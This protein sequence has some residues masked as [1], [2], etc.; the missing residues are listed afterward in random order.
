MTHALSWTHLSKRLWALIPTLSLILTACGG[1]PKP[2]PAPPPPPYEGAPGAVIQG[3]I[4]LP[5]LP[6]IV[7]IMEAGLGGDASEDAAAQAWQALTQRLEDAVEG[8]TLDQISGEGQ[9]EAG[10]WGLRVSAPVVITL[11]PVGAASMGR[12][13][14]QLVQVL[15]GDPPPALAALPAQDAVDAVLSEIS[16]ALWHLR[17]QLGIRSADRLSE[18]LGE[19]AGRLGWSVYPIGAPPPPW[20]VTLDYPEDVLWMAQ[21]PQT[22]NLAVARGRGGHGA[23]DLIAAATPSVTPSQILPLAT[24]PGAPWRGEAE[25]GPAPLAAGAVAVTLKPQAIPALEAAL[26]AHLGFAS[27]AQLEGERR[28]EVLQAVVGLTAAC[29]GLW[30][31][32]SEITDGVSLRLVQEGQGI[33]LRAEVALTARGRRAWRAVVAPPLL[34]AGAYGDSPAGFQIL[35]GR[36]H[37]ASRVDLPDMPRDPIAFLDE[38]GGCGA[39]HPALSSLIALSILPALVSD[40]VIPVPQPDSGPLAGPQPEA[41]AALLLGFEARDGAAAPRVGVIAVGADDEVPADGE[42]LGPEAKLEMT[43]EGPR[44]SLGGGDIIPVGYL[45]RPRGRNRTAVMLAFGGDALADLDRHIAQPTAGGP[46]R[47]FL[48]GWLHP[49]KLAAALETVGAEPGELE[50]LQRLQRRL[51]ALILSGHLEGRRLEYVLRLGQI[52]GA[53]GQGPTANPHGQP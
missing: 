36:R 25:G 27:A 28:V 23:L 2:P 30:Q 39:G 46:R 48:E 3:V 31:R 16:P 13:L 51:G 50:I 42:P 29:T 12:A 11:S 18:A 43:A 14:A 40:G 19:L 4:R 47:L 53:A 38:I 5:D 32:L 45:R 17:V 44:W 6:P 33:D 7:K 21:D 20:A 1:A 35:A 22:G 26:D 24:R 10:G 37:F 52:P 49:G 9:A 34:S 8:L 15:S 41:V